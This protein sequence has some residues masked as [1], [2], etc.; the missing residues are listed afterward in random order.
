[1]LGSI[2]TNTASTLTILQVLY[3][4]LTSIL[5]GLVIAYAYRFCTNAS[6]SFLITVAVLP[7]IVMAI[8]LMVNGNLGIGV[9]V[10]GSFSLVRFRSMPGKASDLAVVFLAM[11]VGLATGTGYI[12]FAIL[13]TI[14]V[15][16]AGLFFAKTPILNTDSTYRYLKITI[17][18]DL[19]YNNAFEDL[20]TTYTKEHHL[21]GIKTVNM[22]AMYL[23]AYQVKLKDNKQE[24]ELIDALRCRNGNLTISSSLQATAAQEL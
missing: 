1:M 22:G 21:E 23:L 16:V 18:E 13:M 4:A 15:V 10:A 12:G 11:G 5:C 3:C 7:A 6:K 8:I 19:D 2:L 14:L 9:A 24:K 20:F 17:P